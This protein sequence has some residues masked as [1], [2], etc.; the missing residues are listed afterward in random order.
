MRQSAPLASRKPW[1]R[2]IAVGSTWCSRNGRM[3]FGPRTGSRRTQVVGK[4]VHEAGHEVGG[5]V[6]ADERQ[7]QQPQ[8]VGDVSCRQP[9]ANVGEHQVLE[10]EEHRHG[11]G[12]EQAHPQGVRHVVV[13]RGSPGRSRSRPVSVAGSED[14]VAGAPISLRR[15]EPSKGLALERRAVCAAPERAR[16]GSGGGIRA[17]CARLGSSG[18]GSGRG[19]GGGRRRCGGSG[20]GSGPAARRVAQP[21]AGRRATPCRRSAARRARR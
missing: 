13:G 10:E 19:R 5:D 14:I 11:R 17:L 1:R 6:A 12:L 7:R 9:V 16:T 8:R 4:E 2:R 15:G 18:G 21:R 20:Q 3:N